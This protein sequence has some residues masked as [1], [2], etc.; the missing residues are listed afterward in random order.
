MLNAPFSLEAL[1]LA[2]R[3]AAAKYKYPDDR[4]AVSDLLSRWNMG[5]GMDRTERRMALRIA[6]DQAAIELPDLGDNQPVRQLASVRKILEAPDDSAG[7]VEKEEP[8]RAEPQDAEAGDDDDPDEL[9]LI[10]Q[11]VA[12]DE[13]PVGDFDEDFYATA[14]K[15]IDD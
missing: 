10:S 8:E 12:G 11:P 5:L 6:R 2:R 3:A 7:T 4:L 14:I 13:D 9:D 1:E 15:D